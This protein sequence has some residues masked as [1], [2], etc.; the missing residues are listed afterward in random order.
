MDTKQMES[1]MSEEEQV[2]FLERREGESANDYLQRTHDV[3]YARAYARLEQSAK[4]LAE[5]KEN[6]NKLTKK[7]GEKPSFN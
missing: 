1:Q 3:Y 7:D 5:I 2:K 6:L 4:I